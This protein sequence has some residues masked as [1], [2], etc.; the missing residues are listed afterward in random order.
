MKF[1]ELTSAFRS[2]ADNL[3][4]VLSRPQW[5]KYKASY[6][7]LA[8]IV[9]RQDR[10]ILDEEIPFQLAKEVCELSKQKFY[11]YYKDT[12]HCL[13]SYQYGDKESFEE[14]SPLE[15]LLRFGGSYIEET[16]ERT[17]ADVIPKKLDDQIEVLGAFAIT[18][19]GMIAFLRS[20]KGKLKDGLQI[21]S[22]DEA[23]E[24]TVIKEHLILVDPYSGYIKQVHQKEQGIRQYVIRPESGAG[25]PMDGEV[26]KIKEPI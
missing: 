21:S 24:W 16:I 22:L 3:N 2:E 14:V 15:I 4:L 17:M 10:A 6:S 26:L 12:P 19:I 8:N 25:K 20:E 23:R 5:A 18:A 9:R 11:L 1:W 7:N 13:A